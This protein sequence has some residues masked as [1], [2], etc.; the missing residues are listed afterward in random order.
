MLSAL[1]SKPFQQTFWHRNATT[2]FSEGVDF[3][4]IF[5][6]SNHAMGDEEK[7][8]SYIHPLPKIFNFSCYVWILAT[9]SCLSC[10]V[11]LADQRMDDQSGPAFLFII[12]QSFPVKR[13]GCL[14]YSWIDDQILNLG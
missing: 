3:F 13:T 10:E 11:V 12:A 6:F 8:L 9:N 4:L 14:R 7:Y 2:N 1:F 5:S